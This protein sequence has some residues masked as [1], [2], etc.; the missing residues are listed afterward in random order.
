M[1][2]T[3]RFRESVASFTLAAA[4]DEVRAL[5]DNGARLAGAGSP[6]DLDANAT[7]L[8][9]SVLALLVR[10]RNDL[11]VT[12]PSARS[13]ERAMMRLSPVDQPPRRLLA[14][15]YRQLSSL[16]SALA[17][18]ERI[19]RTQG[20]EFVELH[21]ALSSVAHAL[22]DPVSTQAG[23]FCT[24]YDGAAIARAHVLLEYGFFPLHGLL[25][26]AEAKALWTDYLHGR[27]R[28]ELREF[29]DP[30]SRVVRAF[31]K[32][33]EI[34]AWTRHLATLALQGLAKHA[35]P[36][37]HALEDLVSEP[38][39]TPA[40]VF[41]QVTRIPG[42]IAG[43]AGRSIYGKDSRTVSGR[44]R[45]EPNAI[46]LELDWVIRDT[47]DFCPGDVGRG[48]ESVVTSPLSRLEAS[49]AAHPV[50][51]EVRFQQTT[52]WSRAG[53]PNLLS[54]R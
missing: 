38:E 54:S 28:G 51:Y 39:L 48:V 32:S 50:P 10:I 16:V 11:G 4:F 33:P 37:E 17:R 41:G 18:V 49:G 7:I 36:S 26:G 29:D 1:A 31:R 2:S 12:L 35:S 46:T 30:G 20:L 27:R 34:E 40:I 6:A 45:V 24:M 19:Q 43:G 9:R 5:A 21:V 14:R 53:R 13:T 47:V 44:V 8:D 15:G 52:R 23:A 25:F 22:V 42:N 3:S